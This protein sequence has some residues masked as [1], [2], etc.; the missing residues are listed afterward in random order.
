MRCANPDCNLMSLDLTTGSLR[1]LELDVPPE[2]RITR[3][4]GGFPICCV[5]SRYFWLCEQCCEFLR[6]RSWTHD[7]LV[8]EY[9]RAKPMERRTDRKD[10][11]EIRKTGARAELGPRLV[12]EKTA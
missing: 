11:H 12:I 6:I 4:D 3:S 9:G 7:G 8:F 1:L 2:E 10:V 5:P